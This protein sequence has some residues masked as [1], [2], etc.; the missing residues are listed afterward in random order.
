M[1][2]LR[3][4]V[5][6]FHP[7][8]SAIL[9]PQPLEVDFEIQGEDISFNFEDYILNNGYYPTYYSIEQE[10]VYNF[11]SAIAKYKDTKFKV[12][13]YL[14]ISNHAKTKYS[15]YLFSS[16]GWISFRGK[17]AYHTEEGDVDIIIDEDD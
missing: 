16:F 1:P 12:G 5:Q 14:I 15:V 3:P 2:R 7:C 10:D 11:V 13:D 8:P 4:G 6:P 17:N 9:D